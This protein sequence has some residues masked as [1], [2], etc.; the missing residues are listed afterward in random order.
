MSVYMNNKTVCTLTQ[1]PGFCCSNSDLRTHNNTAGEEDASVGQRT[2]AQASGGSNA[3]S[4]KDSQEG[5]K[6]ERVTYP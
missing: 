6:H 1:V 2:G 5:I 4:L 3:T